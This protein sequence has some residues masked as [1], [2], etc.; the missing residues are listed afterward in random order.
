MK[1]DRVYLLARIWAV[2]ERD[3]PPLRAA[4]AAMLLELE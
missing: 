4:V 3:L 2:I 1:D